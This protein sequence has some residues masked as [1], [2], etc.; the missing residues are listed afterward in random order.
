MKIGKLRKVGISLLTIFML[1]TL[2]TANLTTTEA[3]DNSVETQNNIKINLFDYNTGDSEKV[4]GSY[5]ND[6]GSW[7]NPSSTY[8]QGINSNH[9][10]KFLSNDA[11]EDSRL[12][13]KW[14]GNNGKPRYNIV[15]KTLNNYG[16]PQ[17]IMG[18]NESLEYLFSTS[19]GTGKQV[20]TNVTGLLTKN[21]DGSFT[22]DSDQQYAE[23][24]NRSKAFTV[25]DAIQGFYYVNGNSKVWSNQNLGVFYPFNSK[26]EIS[27]NAK[28][29]QHSQ[30]N[31]YSY[32]Y[33]Y[34]ADATTQNGYK[35]SDYETINHYFGMTMEADFLQPKDGRINNDDMI[36]EFS[37]DDDVWVFIDGKL[38]LD[39]GGIHDKV[40]GTINF[41]R[42]YVTIKNAQNETVKEYN[43]YEGY[44][45][46]F[47][48]STDFANYTSH[49]IKFYY[50]ERG[51]N[52]SNCKLDFNLA[53]IPQGSV[54]VTKEVIDD[55][56]QS[57]NYS[58]VDF[59]FQIE[60]YN[61][62]TRKWNKV[63]NQEFDIYKNAQATGKTGT[64]DG[65]GKFYLKHE[66]TA[67]FKDI[68]MATDQYRVTET[69]AY[70]DG[71]EISS[72]VGT[73]HEV[74]EDE[75]IVGKQTDPLTVDKNPA[76]TF[77]N[78]I[79]KT[80]QLKINKVIATGSENLLDN[81]TFE[82]TLKINDQVY[83]GTYS[84]NGKIYETS[85]G[86]MTI[87]KDDTISISGLPY[88]TSFEINETENEAYTPTYT[89]EGSVYEANTKGRA[90]AKVNGKD[91]NVTIKNAVDM[92]RKT[93]VSVNK[94]WKDND[95]RDRP[96]NIQVQLYNNDVVVNNQ[97]IVL[98]AD[99]NWQGTF[100]DLPYYGKAA[101][102]QYFVNEYA[103]KEINK[104]NDYIS[105][106]TDNGN[107]SF[108]ITNTLKTSLTITKTVDKVYDVDGDA[109]F[110]F[111]ITNVNTDEF[112]YK[113][114]RLNSGNKEDSVTISDL[115]Y[116]DEYT[117]EEL[118][119]LRYTPSN[120]KF[121]DTG[122]EVYVKKTIK[123][124]DQVNNVHFYNTLTYDH[125]FSH[126]DVVTNEFN[127]NSETGEITITP[128]YQKT[129][130]EEAE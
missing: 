118:D 98:N 34:N 91:A 21:D 117:I 76:V 81:E 97:T 4:W 110:T 12:W 72:S 24:N 93:S 83:N 51:N 25:S 67:V 1:G 104:L 77:R 6:Q 115:K 128:N 17:F 123:L 88:G 126:T 105:S 46:L 61:S 94:V 30:V 57:V 41:A 28:N 47:D 33:G 116:D 112:F 114:L 113:T 99:N 65:N 14:T 52:A 55:N 121:N 49:N 29:N 48:K 18:N 85:N 31:K 7:V 86:V 101:N 63:V 58:D 102:G 84:K 3:A 20:Y 50:L 73:T 38:V 10:F 11:G 89:I 122:K 71:Y 32:G 5:Q 125:N 26:D 54:S 8:N 42:G 66:Q 129:T 45:K 43:M 60:K 36:F 80:S 107:K 79:T 95:Y 78:K 96:E 119:T 16:Y 90:Y 13:N 64:T 9:Q 124:S 53:T 40:T 127:Y 56:N 23:F 22:F 44:G 59:E 120:S 100:T 39:L 37:G 70:L 130:I 68:F 109:I 106:V 15:A 108:T 74:K 92:D 69:G 103:V 2:L 87:D 75:E 27:Y 35:D 82:L 62:G 19:S 111:K